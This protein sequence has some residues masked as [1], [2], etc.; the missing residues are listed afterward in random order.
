MM[1]F[2]FKKIRKSAIPIILIFFNLV[3]TLLGTMMF[4]LNRNYLVDGTEASILWGQTV[5]YASQIFTPILIGTICSISC[6]FEEN[7]KNWQRLLTIPIKP[8]CIILTKIASLSVVMAIS[9][10]LLLFF[11]VLSAAL[12]K[13]SFVGFLPDFL[14]WSITGWLATITIVT[15]QIFIN[16]RLKNFAVPILISA[17]LA[18]AGLMTLFIGNSLFTIFPYTQVA[19]GLR[20]RALVPFTLSELSLFLGLNVIYIILFYGLAVS[21]LKKRFI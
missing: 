10:L 1:I 4:A 12:L 18:M 21:Q 19:V 16:I 8:N 6:Q 13:V 14:L 9:Q 2:E 3:G 5:F 11:Y 17:I 15:I 7:N 20:A